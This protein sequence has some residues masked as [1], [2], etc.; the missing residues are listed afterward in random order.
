MPDD[1]TATNEDRA[2]I[3]RANELAQAAVKHGNHPFGAL[4]VKDGKIIFEYE[5]TIYTTKDA[6]K[7]AECGLI[8][9]ATPKFE[10]ATI[11]ACTL[12]T[13]TEPCIMCC[14]AIRWAGVRKVVYGVG[15]LQLTRVIGI[16]DGP[17]PLEVRE[18][19]QRTEPSVKV[20]GPVNEADG[21][22]IHADYWPQ[23]P[24]FGKKQ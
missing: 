20:I 19:F 10:S 8:S 7:H 12:Y 16:P 1:P 9:A 6:T 2:F 18:I 21:L 22:A 4:L 15:A 5:N 11:E 24:V 17:N 13:S 23:D 3:T 14:G